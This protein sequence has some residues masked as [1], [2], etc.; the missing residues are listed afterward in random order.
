[1][2]PSLLPSTWN[3]HM[4]NIPF[5]KYL[6]HTLLL[7]CYYC[8][9]CW[10]ISSYLLSSQFSR[11]SKLFF[12]FLITNLQHYQFLDNWFLLHQYKFLQG[13]CWL[14]QS[15]VHKLSVT[16]LTNWIKC[17]FLSSVFKDF[18][19]SLP[20]YWCVCTCTHACIW[21]DTLHTRTCMHVCAHTQCKT[22]G[23]C[24]KIWMLKLFT[25]KK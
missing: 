12:L 17:K 24:N 25:K 21:Y 10:L 14:Y 8:W 15:T 13:K 11:T 2:A 20:R 18:S 1:M 6:S 19:L 4:M 3:C 7:V 23:S 5:L 22:K 16:P 9:Y